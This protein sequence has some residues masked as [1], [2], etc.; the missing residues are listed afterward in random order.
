[1]TMGLPRRARETV[2]CETP[3]RSAMSSDVDFSR[4]T[5]HA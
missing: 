5:V 4:F 2:A 1:L 3:A